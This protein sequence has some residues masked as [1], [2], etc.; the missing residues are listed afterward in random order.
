MSLRTGD[1]GLGVLLLPLEPRV[2]V[3]DLLVLTKLH[4]FVKCVLLG[5]RT[6]PTLDLIKC[7]GRVGPT[8]CFG[9]RFVGLV[10]MA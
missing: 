10:I 2:T 4:F 3:I 8:C 6:L 9:I 1:E 7:T 5:F